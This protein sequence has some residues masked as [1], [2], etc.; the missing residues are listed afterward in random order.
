MINAKLSVLDLSSLFKVLQFN[1]KLDVGEA[2]SQSMHPH[3][4]WRVVSVCIQ[5]PSQKETPLTSGPVQ[6]VTNDLALN[7]CLSI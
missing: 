7:F 5:N 2:E 1:L 6:M 3:T 4:E